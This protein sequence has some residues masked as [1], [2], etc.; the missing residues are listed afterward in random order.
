PGI[1]MNSLVF[2]EN[3]VEGIYVGSD[4]GVY[5][6]DASMND[7]IMYSTGLPVDASINEIEIYHSADNPEED[8]IRAG[9]Y[10]RGL[11]SSPVWNDVPVADFES[12]QT[13]IPA[14]C[15]INFLDI[16]TGVP[17]SWEWTFESGVPSSSSQRNPSDI[18]YNVE[19]VFGVSL[20]VSNSE[21]SDTKTITGYITVSEATLPEVDFIA[22]MLIVCTGTEVVFND[23][24]TN[25]PNEWEWEFTPNTIDFTN[26]TD[27]YSQNPEV[28]FNTTGSFTVTLT[29]TNEAGSSSL[30]KDDYIQTG[31]VSLPF[32]ED[33]ESGDFDTKGW[34][35]SNPDADI[36]WEVT[37]VGGSSSGDKAAFINLHDYD[38]GIPRDRL[39]SP[40]LSFVNFN[41]V[42]LSFKHA[43]AQRWLGLTDSLIVYVSDNC[44]ENWIRVFEAGENGE[45]S[46]ATRQPIVSDFVPEYIEDWCGEGW[47]ANCIGI[48]LSDWAGYGN[49]QIMFESYYFHGNNLFIDDIF[50]GPLTGTIEAEGSE[51][52]LRIFPNPSKGV[53]NILLSEFSENVWISVFDMQGE[54]VFNTSVHEQFFQI[55]LSNYNKG[56]Y[57]IQIIANNKTYI[58]KVSVK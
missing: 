19:G 53:V 6:R 46:F 27:Q 22:D 26:G 58:E 11:W 55:D 41:D 47:G 50:V 16:S 20:T 2:Y 15:S 45:G 28:I 56:I 35:I 7:W 51:E 52:R 40:I 39:I 36:T 38:P 10:G 49:M 13:S 25:C 34:T 57:L 4:A 33:F 29:A 5:Y 30:T 1:N 54:Q 42:F 9:T 3:S 43:Y 12:N 44:G 14:G 23:L 18:L 21:G 31:G 24:S 17:S 37:T 48:D 8:V 32:A